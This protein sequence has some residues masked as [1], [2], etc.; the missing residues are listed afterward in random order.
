MVA[1]I[2]A[3]AACKTWHLPGGWSGLDSAPSRRG[4]QPG[5]HRVPLVGGYVTGSDSGHSPAGTRGERRHLPLER[6]RQASR[7]GSSGAGT[8]GAETA[9]LSAPPTPSITVTAGQRAQVEGVP[10]ERT[11][12]SRLIL[13]PNGTLWP[14]D[15]GQTEPARTGRG[16]SPARCGWSR[17]KSPSETG[18]I[19]KRGTWPSLDRIL[20]GSIAL[21]PACLPAWPAPRP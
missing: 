8:G 20:H 16:P 9:M 2:P 5:V 18:I 1:P 6:Q 7:L 13:E 10:D 11:R 15:K 12:K 19:K 14:G 4:R 17:R 3:F 21:F